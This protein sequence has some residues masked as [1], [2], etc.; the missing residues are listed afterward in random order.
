MLCEVPNLAW[1]LGYTNASWTLKV[2]LVARYVVRLL[3]FMDSHGY[4]VASP[5][6]PGD[7]ERAPMVDLESGYVRRG[8]DAF[9]RQGVREPWRLRQNYLVDAWRLRRQGVE[10]QMR[11]ET[12]PRRQLGGEGPG[13]PAAAEEELLVRR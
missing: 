9:P 8:I 12:R 6:P 1:A 3:D 4:A 5:L 11:F 2:D 7:D 10:E 13:I